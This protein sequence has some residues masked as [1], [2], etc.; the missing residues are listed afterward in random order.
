MKGPTKGVLLT[1]FDISIQSTS[2]KQ[3]KSLPQTLNTLNMISHDEGKPITPIIMSR[4]QEYNSTSPLNQI[5]WIKYETK[6][7]CSHKF[8]FLK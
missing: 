6:V 5:Y 7:A 2:I 1:K 4:K 8:T 3:T